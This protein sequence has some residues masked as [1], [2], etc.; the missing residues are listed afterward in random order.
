MATEHLIP[1]ECDGTTEKSKF[2][3]NVRATVEYV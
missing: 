2:S 3:Q 1:R